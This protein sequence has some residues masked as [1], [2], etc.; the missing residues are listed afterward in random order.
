MS[1]PFDYVNAIN[2]TKEEMMRGTDNDQLAEADYV[3]FITN[4]ALSQFADTIM[5]ANEMNM[6]H[7]LDRKPQFE[8]LLHSVRRKKRFGKWA[9]KDESEAIEVI[10]EYYQCNHRR[11]VETL[12]LL[13]EEQINELRRRNMKE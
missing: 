7:H 3:P 11:A 8:Y 10:R 13:T 6:H 9:K 4:K 5:Y 12:G 2:F 1:N